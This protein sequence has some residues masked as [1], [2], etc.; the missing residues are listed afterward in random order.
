MNMTSD[1]VE[2]VGRVVARDDLDLVHAIQ[3]GEVSAFDQ[4]VGRYDLKLLRIAQNVTHNREDSQDTVQESFLKALQHLSEFRGDSQFSTWLFR[5]TVN[6]ALM[7]LRKRRTTI[8]LS[9]DEAFRAD[10]NLLPRE[11]ADGAPNPEELYRTSELRDILIEALQEL[12][13]ILRKVF[14]LRELE[15]L[16]TVQTAEALDL[17]T[18]AVKTRLSRARR[19]VR[20]LVSDYFSKHREHRGR[21]GEVLGSSSLAG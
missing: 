9:L 16:S 1:S 5:I 3:S 6:Q 8:G 15:E 17:S 19:Q 11:V 10:E 12:R 14:V 21:P 18:A 2:F 7:K 4:L 13:P 20:K